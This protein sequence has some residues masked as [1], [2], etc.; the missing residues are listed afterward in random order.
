MPPEHLI[1]P[2]RVFCSSYNP[3]EIYYEFAV[4]KRLK[5]EPYVAIFGPDYY[6]LTNTVKSITNVKKIPHIDT[7]WDT[8]WLR[9]GSEIYINLF[10]NSTLLEK[11]SVN[12]V[13]NGS[14]FH[15]K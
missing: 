6:D 3:D 2:L 13:F 10:P 12:F 8:M 4:C 11:V 1:R 9:G 15:F 5:E 14:S 7:R